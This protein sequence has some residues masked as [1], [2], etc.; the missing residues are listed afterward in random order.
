MPVLP[1]LACPDAFSGC[2]CVLHVPQAHA[3]NRSNKENVT[4][5]GQMIRFRSTL[6]HLLSLLLAGLVFSVDLFL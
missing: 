1:A 6:P 2:R 3:R 4:Y 5:S